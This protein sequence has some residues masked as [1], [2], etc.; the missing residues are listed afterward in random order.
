VQVPQPGVQEA[1]LQIAREKASYGHRKA[2]YYKYALVHLYNGG[3]QGVD[4]GCSRMLN[5]QEYPAS[6]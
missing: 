2:S 3:R 4:A 1:Q 5:Q 6:Q